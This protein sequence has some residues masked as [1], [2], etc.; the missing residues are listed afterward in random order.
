MKTCEIK[1][2]AFEEW[3]A[4]DGSLHRSDVKSK[5]LIDADSF[6]D[7]LDYVQKHFDVTGVAITDL[8]IKE[9]S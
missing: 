9:I 2:C 3:E 7:A 1:I 5:R 8:R 6:K 4:L